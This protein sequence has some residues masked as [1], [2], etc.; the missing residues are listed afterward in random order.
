MSHL[1]VYVNKGN[2]IKRT[3]NKM[4]KQRSHETARES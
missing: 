4:S 2:D 3:D 1:Y